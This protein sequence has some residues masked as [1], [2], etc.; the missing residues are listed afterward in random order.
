M[1]LEST[2][3]LFINDTMLE[4]GL[5]AINILKDKMNV[6]IIGVEFECDPNEAGKADPDKTMTPIVSCLVHGI[7]GMHHYRVDIVDKT[8]E[9]NR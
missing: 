7:S 6:I 5:K 9:L 4:N 1:I 8:I 3:N 2:G